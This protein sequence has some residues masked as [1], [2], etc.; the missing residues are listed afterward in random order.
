[1]R[2]YILNVLISIDQFVNVLI[3]GFPDETIS[4]RAGKALVRVKNGTARGN[5]KYW[6]I[7]CKFLDWLDENHCIKHIE[8][9][10][11]K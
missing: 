10:E 7:L 6:C 5:D 1:M 3:G 9:D 2:N 11:G 4:S 8:Y